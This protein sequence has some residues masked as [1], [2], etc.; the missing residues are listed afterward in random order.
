MISSNFEDFNTC[1]CSR[2]IWDARKRAAVKEVAR[3]D[4]RVDTL[5]KAEINGRY[6][7]LVASI[8]D[9]FCKIRVSQRERSQW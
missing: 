8:P 1:S 7:R 4:Q 9:E 5:C 6:K 2:A 3:N